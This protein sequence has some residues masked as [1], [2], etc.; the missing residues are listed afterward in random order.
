MVII[1]DNVIIHAEKRISQIIVN[2]KHLICF[3]LPYSPDFNPIELL[4]SVLK[5]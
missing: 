5:L 4:F 3:L 1:L 2:S